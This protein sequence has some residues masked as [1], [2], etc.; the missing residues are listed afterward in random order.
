MAA[1]G[2][3]FCFAVVYCKST[4]VVQFYLIVAFSPA[5]HD[6]VYSIILV[7]VAVWFVSWL[8]CVNGFVFSCRVVRVSFNV[9]LV[10][11][12]FFCVDACGY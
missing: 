6:I 10:G 4:N 1:V 7:V 3:C 5:S 12:L 8:L 11:V 2:R 9:V